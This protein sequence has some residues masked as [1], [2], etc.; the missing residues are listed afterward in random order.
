MKRIL[1]ALF[2]YWAATERLLLVIVL[3]L[4]ILLAVLQILLR[5]LFDTSLFWIDPFNRLLVLWLAVLGAMVATREREHIAIDALKHYFT[6]RASSM[7]S[8][9]TNRQLSPN[10]L[11]GHLN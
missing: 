4:L 3:L 2:D 7:M 1:N 9:P 5:N 10:S 11:P 8:S 6:Q